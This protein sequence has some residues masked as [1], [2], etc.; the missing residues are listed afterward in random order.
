MSL[1]WRSRPRRERIKS[2]LRDWNQKVSERRKRKEG[3][4]NIRIG[5]IWVKYT[6]Y[7]IQKDGKEVQFYDIRLE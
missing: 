4:K 2:L 7:W 3:K 6:I 1:S 5:V